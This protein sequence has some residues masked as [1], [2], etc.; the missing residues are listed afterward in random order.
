MMDPMFMKASLFVASDPLEVPRSRPSSQVGPIEA[1]SGSISVCTWVDPLMGTCSHSDKGNSV[2][3]SHV[4]DPSFAKDSIASAIFS[5]SVSLTVS[6][7]QQPESVN[8]IPIVPRSSTIVPVLNYF[9]VNIRSDLS[10][11]FSVG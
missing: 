6:R 1:L 11:D 9:S 4:N 3:P 5:D 8:A 7:E 2:L 10:L